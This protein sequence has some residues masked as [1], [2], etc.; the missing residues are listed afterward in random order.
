M[1]DERYPVGTFQP[2]QGPLTAQ[3]RE[4]FIRQIEEAP[5]HLRAAVSGLSEQQLETPYRAGG[6]TVRQATHHVPD[7]HMNAYTRFRLAL[8]EDH[9]TIKPYEEARWAELPDSRTAPLEMS[10]SLL[11]AVHR[12]WTF[13][14]KALSGD[15]WGRTFLHPDGNIVYTLDRALAMYAWHGRHHVAHITGLRRRMGW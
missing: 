11:D 14:L 5:R 8:T 4:G 12:R 3:E 15:Q 2:P 9:P 13:M 10:L 1:D 6:W 7:S